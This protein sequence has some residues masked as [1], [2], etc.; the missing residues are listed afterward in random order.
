MVVRTNQ[1]F[2]VYL[3]ELLVISGSLKRSQRTES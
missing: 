3:V 2:R 1:S